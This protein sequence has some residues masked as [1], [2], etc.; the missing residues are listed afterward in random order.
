MRGRRMEM[1]KRIVVLPALVLLILLT[2]SIALVAGCGATTP[3]QARTE[4]NTQLQNLKSA[5]AEF[6]NPTTYASTDS[7]KSAAKNVQKQFDNVITAGKD[8]KDVSTSKLSSAWNQLSKSITNL[9][10]SQSFSQKVDAVQ[11]AITNFQKA[12]QEVFTTNNK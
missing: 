9:S 7:I 12:W 11:S 10:S 6:T 4:L 1:K 2:A 8:V 3:A 5:L